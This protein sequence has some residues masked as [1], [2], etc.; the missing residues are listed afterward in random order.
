M[1]DADFSETNQVIQKAAT[2]S[3]GGMENTDVR[4]LYSKYKKKKLDYI[5]KRK[6]VSKKMMKNY[7]LSNNDSDQQQQQQ[8]EDEVSVN[9]EKDGYNFM[10]HFG[11]ME[12][13][14][15]VMIALAAN[16]IYYNPVVL[17]DVKQRWYKFVKSI[18]SMAKNN[19]WK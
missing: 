19:W 8:K 3:S 11:T 7:N 14:L 1:G 2:L 16:E 6:E 9:N 17:D 5:E 4:K 13:L 10:R 18:H 15:L 12:F